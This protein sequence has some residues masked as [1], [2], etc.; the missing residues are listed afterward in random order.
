MAEQKP[1]S[2]FTPTRKVEYRYG[3]VVTVAV[4]HDTELVWT[5]EADALTW[6][7]ELAF[8][9]ASDS[10]LIA[11]LPTH[12]FGELLVALGEAVTSLETERFNRREAS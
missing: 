7:C 4:T 2:I 9:L 5:S 1:S 3:P 11:N 6:A 12:R 8:D 10:D